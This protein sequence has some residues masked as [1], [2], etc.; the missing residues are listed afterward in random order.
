LAGIYARHFTEKELREIVG[1]FASPSGNAW[2]ARRL[3]VQTESEQ[4]GLEWG[5]LLTQR[6][7]QNFKIKS[8]D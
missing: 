6:V 2:L 7:F 8:N 4:L 3:I 1:F 5:K